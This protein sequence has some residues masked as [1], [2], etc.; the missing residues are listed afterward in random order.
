MKYVYPQGKAKALTFSYDDGQEYD[1]KLVAIFNQHGLKGTF[2]LNSG[3]LDGRTDG[4]EFIKSTE[5]KELYKGHEVSCHGVQHI[6]LPGVS[7]QQ[8]LVE[9]YEDRKALE[10]L[11]GKLVQ[12]MSY[13][14][15]GYT[16]EVERVA[17]TVGLKYSRTVNSTNGFFPPDNFLE[18][19]PT[20]HHDQNL[21]QLGKDFLNVPDYIEMPLMY[22]WG[23]SFEF[24]RKNDWS[25]IEE[26]A[27]MMSGKEDIWYATNLEICDYLTA[28]RRLEFMSDGSKVYNPSAISVWVRTTAGQ[29]M[30]LKPGVITEVGEQKSTMNRA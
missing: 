15:G 3:T 23:H 25:V 29:L 16:P 2:H 22:V 6:F 7:R 10:A 20:C 24:G 19:H 13:A 28:V 5:V 12:G 26:F 4:E 8:M 27:Q 18:W 17:K 21:I 14:F 9:L 30:E 11:T 1:R